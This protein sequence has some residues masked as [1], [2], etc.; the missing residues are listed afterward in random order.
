MIRHACLFYKIY[1]NFLSL[2]KYLLVSVHPLFQSASTIS[3]FTRF[4]NIVRQPNV[5]SFINVRVL[6][7]EQSRARTEYRGRD[8]IIARARDSLLS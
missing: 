7:A 6:V 5:L 8:L 2:S 3:D 4:R 1:S